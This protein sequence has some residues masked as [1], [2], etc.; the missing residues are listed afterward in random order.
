MIE[1]STEDRALGLALR[2]AAD[3]QT[4]PDLAARVLARLAADPAPPARRWGAWMLAAAAA[5]LVITIGLGLREGTAAKPAEA[6]PNAAAIQDP[7][8]DRS[9][10]EATIHIAGRCIDGT[11]TP[12]EGTKVHLVHSA[13][14]TEQMVESVISDP[15]G[16]FSFAPVPDVD[17]AGTG[18]ETWFVIAERRGH[19]A[20]MV[21]L[22]DVRLDPGALTMQLTDERVVTGTVVD[23]RGAPISGATV[24]PAWVDPAPLAAVMDR[25]EALARDGRMRV[26]FDRPPPLWS[27]RTD[28][29]GRYRL[30]GLPAGR[31]IRLG[32][33][34]PQH[35]VTTGAVEDVAGR[36]S[37]VSF[38][39]TP[40][41]SLRGT[42]IDHDGT[43]AASVWVSAQGVRT[44]SWGTARTDATGT[45]AITS[46]PADDYNVWANVPG[47]TGVALESRPA[48]ED[49]A[50]EGQVTL[51]PLQLVRGVLLRGVVR[52][53]D[54]STLAPGAGAV[55]VQGSARP[56]CGAAVQLVAVG[57]GGMFEVR[58][59]PGR[60]SLY[61]AIH[62]ERAAGSRAAITLD[63]DG[64][65]SIELESGR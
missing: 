18:M 42:V 5:V 46:M 35:A 16:S 38:V 58:L 39:L 54:G 61:C 36:G 3:Q 28:E 31:P 37:E 13:A 9:G 59:P 6:T 17:T 12:I 51:P 15:D 34:G 56:E 30:R 48:A 32:A 55:Y 4:P 53:A 65:F 20:A 24:W 19:G 64:P 11:G 49:A 47:R 25:R 62:G 21:S 26:T 43:P 60:H 2:E 29:K 14:V 33:L 10:A 63:G 57:D 7:V 41:F 44:S 45:Y 22:R 52:N 40:G 27:T 1:P 23:R 50:V 8:P